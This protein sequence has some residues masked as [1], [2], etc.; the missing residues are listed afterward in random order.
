MSGPVEVSGST[1]LTQR[2]VEARQT[3]A[4]LIAT[5]EQVSA[6][7]HPYETDMA[8]VSGIRRKPNHRANAQR[9][10]RY[11]REAAAWEKVRAAQTEVDILERRVAHAAETAPV[12]FTEEDLRSARYVRDQHG[13]HEVARVNAKS[14]SVRTGYSWT[15]RIPRD[16]IL[17]VRPLADSIERGE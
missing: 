15:D 17:E 10:S 6:P 3:L 2:L 4:V 1:P 12:P 14:V 13:W 9:Y 7:Q 16:R 5:A 11:D 8:V